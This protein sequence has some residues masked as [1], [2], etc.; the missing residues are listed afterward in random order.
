VIVAL[1]LLAGAAVVA[2]LAPTRLHR[3]RDTG[4]D[5]LMLIVAWL[6][7][8][9][10]V[11][12]TT[13]AG[14]TALLV[15]S[16][17]VP[18]DLVA[19][20]HGCWAVLRHGS[21][22]QV[23]QSAGLAGWA[24]VAALAARLTV[25]ARR[26]Q[27]RRSAARRARLD[28]L[29]LAGR[30]EAGSPATLWLAHDRPLAFSL[31]GRP[32]YVVATEGLTRRLTSEQVGAVLEHERAH[33]RGRHHTLLA[34]VDALRCVLPFLPLL[35]HAPAA[36]RE[37]VELSADVAAVRRHGALALRAALQRVADHGVAG[38]TPDSALA[39][40]RDAV[41]LRLRRLDRAPTPGLPTVRA[42][43][44]VAVGIAVGAVPLLVGAGLLLVTGSLLC[45]FA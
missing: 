37:L 30:T 19:A 25:I 2:V 12:F 24:V 11:L 42:A 32:G 29:R 16:H 21:P 41:D 13:T 33:L 35:R 15:P 34:A 4:I 45:P 9:A 3:L 14:I 10:G 38:E 23:E 17:G 39:A 7:S 43:R 27:R 8:I 44:C 26:E 6:L 22:P 1:A 31:A 5:P 28:M 18:G 40:G 36:L 20:V